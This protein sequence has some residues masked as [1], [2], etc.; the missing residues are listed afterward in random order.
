MAGLRSAHVEGSASATV[1]TFSGPSVLVVDE[2]GYL[3]VDADS[4]H[5]TFQ[6]ASRRYESAARSC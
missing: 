4:A 2:L 3:P 6:V 1:R 5:C